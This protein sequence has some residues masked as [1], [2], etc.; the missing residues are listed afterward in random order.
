M[1]Q[2]VQL[3]FS[4]GDFQLC[5]LNLEVTQGQYFVLL[6]P[7]GSGKTIF[8]ECLCGLK[9]IK[10]GQIYIDGRNV[11][12][13]EPRARDIG[14]V[15]Q[16]Y[17]L[18]PH[19]SVKRNIAFGLQA[20]G[21]RRT[22]I[23]NKVM[24]TAEV[25]SIGHLLKRSVNGLSGGERQRIALARALVLQPKVLLFDEPVCALDE[26]TRQ[27]ICTELHQLQRQ[28]GVTTI[29]VSHNLEEAFSIA[30][31]AGILREGKLQQVGFINE[32]LRKPR[33]EFIARFMRCENIFTGKVLSPGPQPESTTVQCGQTQ[34]VVPGQHQD[35]IKFM[36]RPENVHLSASDRHSDPIDNE[37]RVK[38]ACARDCGNYV[39]I[40]LKG[41]LDLVAHVPYA[42]FANM[43]AAV[44]AELTA[45]LRTENIHVLSE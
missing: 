9:R 24:Q 26:A 33:N 3:S 22:E 30:D 35:R 36:I 18:F 10:S 23:S 20:R 39:H 31:K 37:F 45:V 19:L 42:V 16:D 21:W 11:T 27:D 8:L 12:N 1:I 5:R 6:G 28:F 15:P 44:G 38:L 4:I 34:L 7:P 13:L 25:L 41:P 14:Y 43:Q 29:H 2:T 17:A 32:L 40:E